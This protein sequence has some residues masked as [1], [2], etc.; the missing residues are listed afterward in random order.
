MGSQ[1]ALHRGNFGIQQFVQL[2]FL[3]FC[4][5]CFRFCEGV[6]QSHKAIPGRGRRCRPSRASRG[7][8]AAG[9][10]NNGSQQTAGIAKGSKVDILSVCGNSEEEKS[11][12]A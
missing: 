11:Q 10:G 9:G 7:S 2:R 4:E 5:R 1:R 12:E 8:S 3:F 6:A